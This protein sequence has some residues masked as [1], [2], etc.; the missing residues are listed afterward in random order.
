MISWDIYEI[1]SESTSIHGVKFRGRIRKYSISQEFDVLVEN[2]N[3]KENCV[4]F[5]VTKDSDADKIV[6]FIDSIVNDVSINK[7]LTGVVNPVLSKLKVNQLD[8]YEI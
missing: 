8:R 2:S 4:R 6:G 3:D 1:T 7:V 5:A